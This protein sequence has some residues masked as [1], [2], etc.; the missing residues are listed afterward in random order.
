VTRRLPH[1]VELGGPDGAPRAVLVHGLGGS[2]ANWAGLG[3]ALAAAT[4]PIAPDLAGFGY[5]PG[6]GRAATVSANAR[7]LARFLR[8]EVGEPAVLVGNSMGGMI[9]AITAA[10]H[11][12]LVSAVVLLD[13]VL[14]RPR[15]V[16]VDREAGAGILTALLPVLGP[17]RLTRIRTTVPARDRVLGTLS[18]CSRDLSKLTERQLDAEITLTETR[19][20]EGL[21]DAAA[22]A[23]AA[24]SLV[25]RAA[26]RRYRRELAAI[27]APVLLLHGLHDRLVPL[28]AADAAAAAHPN[29]RYQRQDGGHTPHMELPEETAGIITA[30]L[31]EQHGAITDSV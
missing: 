1:R 24:R 29:W 6:A 7:L 8:E 23:A 28:A 20:A 2:H 31:E 25:L 10:A 22:Y 13:P 14:P 11:P 17:R 5:T 21:A 18:I 3:P 12:E 4:R 26:G 9:S 30:W 27:T 19:E 16:A 15:G